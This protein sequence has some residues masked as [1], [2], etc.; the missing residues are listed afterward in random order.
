MHTSGP[1]DNKQEANLNI[2]KDSINIIRQEII[3]SHLIEKEMVQLKQ[4]P[5]KQ[6]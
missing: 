2:N 5:E 1:Q 6:C 4:V 3:R